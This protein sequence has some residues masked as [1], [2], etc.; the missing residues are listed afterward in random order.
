MS[1]PRF[2]LSPL[3]AAVSLALFS[4]STHAQT[5]PATD[6]AKAA[7]DKVAA[8]KADILQLDKVIIT[9]TS[10]VA[11]KMKQ[12]VSVSTLNSDAIEQGNASSAAE[13]L[14]SIPGVRSESSGG[15]SNA[16]LTVRGLPISAGGARYVQFQEDG[17]PILQFGDIAFATPDSW[18]RIDGMLE[19]LEVVRGG[20]SST[21]AT[22][23]PGGII[24]FI[25]NTGEETGGS[26]GIS[27]GIDY[28]TTRYDFGYGGALGAN[29]HYFIG[30]FYRNGEGVRNGGVNAEQGGQLR[31]N[32]TQKFSTGFLRL[33]FKHLDDHAPTLLPVPVRFSSN[34]SI[35]T[36]S[37]ID[38]R[39]ASFYSPYLIPDQTLTINN[40]RTATNINDG[41]TAKTDAFGV[42]GSFD[43]RR[44][45]SQ[46]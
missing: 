34:G 14:R 30:G 45:H 44:W 41:L 35:S 22:N 40:G 19:R 31:G 24:N 39:R 23:A 8:D 5:A 25:S 2:A 37:G 12:S 18:V 13:V 10:T 4:L 11:S 9:G 38:P 36:I 16:N 27:R 20:S 26:F 29:T 21:T 42:E 1:N 28:D 15:E 6:A 46:K 32:I 43:L 17:L 7:A 33:S 3:A